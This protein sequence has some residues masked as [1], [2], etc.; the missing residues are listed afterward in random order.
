MTA[1]WGITADKFLAGPLPEKWDQETTKMRLEDHCRALAQEGNSREDT[2]RYLIEYNRLGSDDPKWFER[3]LP[4]LVARHEAMFLSWDRE[5]EMEEKCSPVDP[6][7]W[8]ELFHTY[9]DV[10]NTP[11]LKF[12]IHGWLQAEG[13]TMYGGLPGHGKTLMD[14][15]PRGHC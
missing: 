4:D 8:G 5:T 10:I 13:I 3:H 6:N 15:P 11:P 7:K 1:P 9:E 12:A 2:L 14:C